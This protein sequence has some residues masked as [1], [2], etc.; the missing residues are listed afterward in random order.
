MKKVIFN[1]YDELAD[2]IDEAVHQWGFKSRAEF[3]RYTAIDFLRR[4][5]HTLPSDETL[6]EYTRGFRA[7]KSGQGRELPNTLY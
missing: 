4:D 6:K 5:A 3:F 7:I 2:R 1:I